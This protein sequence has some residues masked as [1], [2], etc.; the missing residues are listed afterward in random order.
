[1]FMHHGESYLVIWDVSNITLTNRMLSMPLSRML[2]MPL[3]RMPLSRMLSMPLSRMLRD[4][5]IT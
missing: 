4:H 3:S 5:S 2:S 1:M